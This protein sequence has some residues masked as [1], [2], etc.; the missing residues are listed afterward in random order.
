MNE[1]ARTALAI[2]SLSMVY[3]S[4][5]VLATHYALKL[6]PKRPIGPAIYLVAQSLSIALAVVINVNWLTFGGPR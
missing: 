5:F 2:L 3:Y 1:L 6:L 4:S